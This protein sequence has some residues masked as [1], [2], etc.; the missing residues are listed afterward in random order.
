VKKS[1]LLAIGVALV[2]CAGMACAYSI[3]LTPSTVVMMAAMAPVAMPG[4]VQELFNAVFEPKK[5]FPRWYQPNP[6]IGQILVHSQEQEDE[7]AARDW[8]PKPL[9]GS[10]GPSPKL[11]ADEQI[12]VMAEQ[13][14]A[15]QAQMAAMM[16]QMASAGHT[17]ASDDGSGTQVPGGLSDAAEDDP[18]QT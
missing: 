2:A 1:I 3:D 18:E 11:S 10:E 16:A 7:L 8:S 4:S 9:P 17:P 14:A 12:K 13:M 5:Q 15:M 6:G